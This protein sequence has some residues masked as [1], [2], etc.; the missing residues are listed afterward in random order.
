[1]KFDPT[2]GEQWNPEEKVF[3]TYRKTEIMAKATYRTLPPKTI[4]RVIAH[5]LGGG[6]IEYHR[7]INWLAYIYQTRKK[8]GTAWI[9]H[10][11]QGTGKGLL[12][13]HILTP[14]FGA[15][16]VRKQQARD[17]RADFNGWMETAIFVNLDEFDVHDTGSSQDSIMAA[18]K[19]WITD[20]RLSIRALY[21]GH[22]MTDNFTNFIVTTNSQNSIPVPPGERRFSYG[23]RQEEKIDITPADVE[24]IKAELADF[25]GYLLGYDV[26][27]E[28]AHQC[29]ENETKLRAQELS[30][31]TIEEFVEA[32]AIGDL[33]Y[34]YEILREHADFDM[35]RNYQ[36]VLDRMTAD[37]KAD[38]QTCL[39]PDEM[40]AA[41]EMATGGKKVKAKVMKTLAYK[42]L[43][44]GRYQVNGQRVRGFLIKWNLSEEDKTE[45]GTHLKAVVSPKEPGEKDLQVPTSPPNME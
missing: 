13:D 30:K 12:V 7:F 2:Y 23:M 11:V 29:L 14:I 9:M 1:M 36:Q 34:F 24:M 44:P 15:D 16:Y 19:N 38:K 4:T 18:L 5:A 26:N 22:R 42:N 39:S 27:A 32:V 43:K 10:G 28:E 40:L 35:G 17:L 37:A 3:N 21:A 8:T 31:N 6:E 20:T 41:Y 25:A 33:R 45:L